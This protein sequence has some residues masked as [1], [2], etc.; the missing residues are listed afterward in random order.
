LQG[1]KQ[2]LP[3][4]NV[5]EITGKAHDQT[6]AISCKVASLK[7]AVIARGSSRRKA[8]QK[9]ARLVLEKLTNGE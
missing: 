8:E 6:F 9:A 1:R 2:P 3:D 4:Y 7:Q 5:A